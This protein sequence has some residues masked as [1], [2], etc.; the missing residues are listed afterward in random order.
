M[1]W[2]ENLLAGTPQETEGRIEG[3][4]GPKDS[5]SISKTRAGNFGYKDWRFFVSFRHLVGGS[6]GFVYVGGV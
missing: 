6:T 4:D 1:Y 5:K 2:L 3:M